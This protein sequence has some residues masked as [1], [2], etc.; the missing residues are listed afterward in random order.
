MSQ[1]GQQGQWGQSTQQWGAPRPQQQWGGQQGWNAPQQNQQWGSPG[2]YA[3]NQPQRGR[4]G[5]GASPLKWMI[6]AIFTI[7]AA[8]MLLGLLGGEGEPQGQGQ[9][10]GQ[11]PTEYQNED[12]Q[13]PQ[14]DTAPVDFP[15]PTT[16]GEATDWLQ[17][18]PI[19]SASI[20]APTRC[21]SQ[22]ID[23]ENASDAQLEQHFNELTGC[24]MRAFDEPMQQAGYVLPRPSVTI[25][26]S[27]IATRCGTMPMYNAAYCTADQQI[28]YAS[29]LPEIIPSELDG[30]LYAVESV[31]AHE[32]AHHIQNRTGILISSA[33]WEQ[34]SNEA[35]ANNFARRLEVQADCFAGQFINSAGPSVGIDEERS[36]RLSLLFYAIGDDVLTG[37]PN[38][39]GNHGHGDSRRN[40]YWQGYSNTSM[41]ACNTY[42]AP[43]SEVR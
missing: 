29:N 12:Y 11:E 39:D 35:G 8:I 43:D 31:V 34:N 41:G 42:V 24:L 13:V 27:E 5:G 25:Y 19:Y 22:P 17:N 21:E 38:I 15:K 1:W 23:L 26:S 6:I 4:G 9:G 16:Y 20:P 37:D 10:Q 32:F 28:Y 14:I 36:N 33:A 2:R 18:N 3:P 7:L 40:W 30:T